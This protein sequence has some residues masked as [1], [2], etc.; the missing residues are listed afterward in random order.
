MVPF[1]DEHSGAITAIATVILVLC[2]I[3][4]I[5]VVWMQAKTMRR[6]VQIMQQEANR[7]AEAERRRILHAVQTIVTDIAANGAVVG[8]ERPVQL[9]DAGYM[10]LWALHACGARIET[11]ASVGMAY[12]AVKEF[13]AAYA[14]REFDRR[15]IAWESAQEALRKADMLLDVDQAVSAQEE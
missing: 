7:F 13:N 3:A 2:T 4:Y 12:M 14:S 15:M 1:C 11:V 8:N 9:S 10:F 5:V 6:Q